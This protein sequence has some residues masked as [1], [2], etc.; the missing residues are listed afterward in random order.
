MF[1]ETRIV[2]KRL[3]ERPDDS[4]TMD[5][6]LASGCYDAL[7]EVLAQGDPDGDPGAGHEVGA[8]RA[9]AARTSPPV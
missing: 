4:W 8:A 7:R 5:G 1:E 2:T 6:A 3:Y 9:G